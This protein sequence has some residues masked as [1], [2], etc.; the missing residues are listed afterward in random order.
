M[1]L[2]PPSLAVFKK[3]QVK[4]QLRHSQ[5]YG[6]Q[7]QHV[8]N[9]QIQRSCHQRSCK[10]GRLGCEDSSKMGGGAIIWRMKRERKK[11]DVD[12]VWQF[13]QSFFVN[14]SNI[15]LD[16]IC[17]SISCLYIYIYIIILLLFTL[18]FFYISLLVLQSVTSF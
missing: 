6:N 13:F 8:P 12:N 4:K 1:N 11:V 14:Y 17:V 5:S 16:I 2:P 10:P 9:L 18:A 3:R 15:Q 7:Y